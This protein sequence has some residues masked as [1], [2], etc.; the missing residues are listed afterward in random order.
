MQIP[1]TA[2]KRRENIQDVP[3]AIAAITASDLARMVCR[4]LLMLPRRSR[5]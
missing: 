4:T 1:L 2:N 5:A 3:I